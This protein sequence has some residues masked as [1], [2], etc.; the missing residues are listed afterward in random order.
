MTDRMKTFLA[1]ASSKVGVT[2]SMFNEYKQARK[3]GWIKSSGYPQNSTTERYSITD[4]G[5]QALG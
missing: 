4:K 2:A 5:R 3:E 1:R